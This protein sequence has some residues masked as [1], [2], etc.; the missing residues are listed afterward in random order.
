MPAMASVTCFIVAGSILPRASACLASI[1]AILLGL[2]IE[3]AG[4]PAEARS[5]ISKSPN[6]R[7]FSAL[8]II[9]THNSALPSPTWARETTSA[10]RCWRVDLSV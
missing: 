4:S 3:A 9:T 8:V 7:R 5:V 2:M 1:V 6:Q 10:G